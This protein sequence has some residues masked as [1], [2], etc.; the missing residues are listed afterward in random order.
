[1]ELYIKTIPA[2]FVLNKGSRKKD[3]NVSARIW[4]EYD[5]QVKKGHIKM[6]K[7]KKIAVSMV[8][9]GILIFLPESKLYASGSINGN[10]A[11]VLE[12]LSG[13]FICNGDVYIVEPSYK[14][15]L[16]AY[17]SEDDVDLTAEQKQKCINGIVGN[18]EQAVSEGYMLKVRTASE[19]KDE[20]TSTAQENKDDNADTAQENKKADV[21]EDESGQLTS[22]ENKEENTVADGDSNGVSSKTMSSDKKI[23]NNKG[24]TRK[25]KNN[26]KDDEIGSTLSESGKLT[27]EE[28]AKLM[29]KWGSEIAD[30]EEKAERI[31]NGEDIS[32]EKSDNDLDSK[33]QQEQKKSSEF[34][35]D[36]QETKSS[37]NIENK[38]QKLKQNFT[39]SLEQET[40]HTVIYIA[41]LAIVVIILGTII[42][43][44]RKRPV[45]AKTEYTD[46][47]SHILPGVDDGAKDMETTKSMLRLAK[48]QGIH[49][50]IATPHYKVGQY[51]VTAKQLEELQRQVQQEAD[52]EGIDI[53]ILLGNELY[54]S[55]DICSRLENKKALT[56][57]GS[58]YVLVEFSPT[59][60]YTE[61]YQGM[62]ELIQEGY[63]P[64]LAHIER[65]DCLHKE[66]NKDKIQELIRLGVYMQMNVQSLQKRYWRKLVKG[67]YIH[68][69]GSDSHNT[70]N[71]SP[72]MQEG[73]KQ[74]GRMV[75]R[76]QMEKILIENPQCLR[77]NKFI[78]SDI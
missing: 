15:A 3:Y 2:S 67:G 44:W 35:I 75:T 74:L 77:E 36:N 32:E 22:S 40:E 16:R 7:C 49:T 52:K 68:F 76:K 54:Y 6:R 53:E 78:H 24:K 34:V 42:R 13:E 20:S 58:R 66:K 39:Y 48:K 14:E 21:S 11:A 47:H 26:K 46:I 29:E 65:Y 5:N 73:L 12:V 1:M 28:R 72:K 17:F 69:L 19:N 64:I 27:E 38:I 25:K 62:R 33:S 50:I 61:I 4:N 18:V 31:R 56:L 63:A 23:K 59:Q 41:G 37:N 57:A 60:P 55:R 51:K 9:L 45:L 71:R 30:I 43:L 8:M 10:E 70:K